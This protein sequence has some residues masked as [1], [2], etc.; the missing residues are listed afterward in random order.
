LVFL[1][2]DDFNIRNDVK[3]NIIFLPIEYQ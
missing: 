3:C 1:C 2:N